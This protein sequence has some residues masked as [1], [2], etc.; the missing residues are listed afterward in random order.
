[1]SRRELRVRTSL[2]PRKSTKRSGRLAEAAQWCPGQPELLELSPKLAQ[3]RHDR[4][5][6]ATA[7][8]LGVHPEHL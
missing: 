8:V 5:G 1:M 6:H 7:W 2:P 4:E 3:G